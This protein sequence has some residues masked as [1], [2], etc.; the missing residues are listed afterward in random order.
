M[1]QE[2]ALRQESIERAQENIEQVEKQHWE[3]KYQEEKDRRFQ[4][5]QEYQQRLEEQIIPESRPLIG[6]REDALPRSRRSM[7]SEEKRKGRA[8]AVQEVESIERRSTRVE[9]HVQTPDYDWDN[10]VPMEDEARYQYR[11]GGRMASTPMEDT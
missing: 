1:D 4:E 2:R 3:E 6:I 5:Q 8:A 10:Y 7:E 9:H 11:R